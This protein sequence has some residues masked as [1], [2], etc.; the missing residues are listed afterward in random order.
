MP[1]QTKPMEETAYANLCQLLNNGVV[2]KTKTYNYT[3]SE[4]RVNSSNLRMD[5]L[6][7]KDR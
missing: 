4:A 3:Q 5:N 1:E 6:Q 2:S 7:S